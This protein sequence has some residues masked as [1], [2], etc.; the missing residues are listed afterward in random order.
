MAADPNAGVFEVWPENWQVWEFFM[1]HMQ[2]QWRVGGAGPVGFD[3]NVLPWLFKLEAI[4]DERKLL[5]ELK[6]I[7]VAILKMWG[8]EA[9]T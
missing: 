8:E 3:Y 4:A 5:A 1:D 6:T 9:A 2:T 7:E